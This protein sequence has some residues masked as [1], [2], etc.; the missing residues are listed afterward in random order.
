MLTRE[1]FLQLH[2]AHPGHVQ[3]E[4]H[5]IRLTFVHDNRN[6][7]P[8]EYSATTKPS[9]AQR[10]ATARRTAASSS[11]SA[12][13]ARSKSYAEYGRDAVHEDGEDDNDC[14]KDNHLILR[15]AFA[16]EGPLLVSVV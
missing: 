11:T 12:M 6:S 9:A 3:I 7:A 13:L 16:F 8:E 10:R 5:A 15:R 1:H 14:V 2:A 4:H